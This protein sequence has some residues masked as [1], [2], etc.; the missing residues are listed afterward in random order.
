[1]MKVMKIIYYGWFRTGDYGSIDADKNL[2]ICG[3][4]KNL[5]VLSN[6]KNVI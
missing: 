4:K 5:I 2:V 3:R 6:G 1:M